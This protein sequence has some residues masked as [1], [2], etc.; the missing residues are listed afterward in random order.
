MNILIVNMLQRIDIGLIK[1]VFVAINP[2]LRANKLLV[3]Q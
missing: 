1:T 2:M 3:L